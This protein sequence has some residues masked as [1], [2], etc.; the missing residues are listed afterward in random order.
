MIY[1]TQIPHGVTHVTLGFMFNLTNKKNDIPSSVTHLVLENNYCIVIR[2]SVLPSSITYLKLGE[3]FSEKIY[4]ICYNICDGICDGS[5][6]GNCYEEDYEF[7]YY[8]IK[9]GSIPNGVTHLI[10][11]EKYN[12]N[13]SNCIPDSVYYLRFGEYTHQRYFS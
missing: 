7:P 2:P 10:F 5:C 12:K 1:P 3:N 6:N 8:S 9:P 4:K 11:P 13:L